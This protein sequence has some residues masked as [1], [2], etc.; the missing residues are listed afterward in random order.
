MALTINTNNAA[1]S[2]ARYLSGTHSALQQSLNRLSSGKRINEPSDDA[3]GLAVSVKLAAAIKRTSAVQRNVENAISFM[4]TQDGAL[5]NVGM[6]LERMSELKMLYGDVTK[7]GSDKANYNAEFT[8]LFTQ[9]KSMKGE[10]F[11]GVTLFG[12]SLGSI[13]TNEDGT[14][15]VTLSKCTIG[16]VVSQ[17]SVSS[18]GGFSLKIATDAIATIARYRATNG[19][20]T[21]RLQFASQ[22][23]SINKV[24]LESANSRIID[25]DI[26]EESTRFA[27]LQ[28]LAQA[29]AAM[30]AQAN[31]LPQVAL[32]LI[33]Q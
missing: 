25:T 7:S 5:Q 13:G 22:M 17:L 32:K 3:G 19:G 6:V 12:A 1:S 10:K 21:N 16:T 29:N 8:Q 28:I 9:L 26:A 30:L 23:L 33:G 18:L 20:Q 11:N 31:T 14:Q 27:K 2:A 15:K 24:N 4:Q